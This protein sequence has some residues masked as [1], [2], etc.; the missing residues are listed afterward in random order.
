MMLKLVVEVCNWAPSPFA[1]YSDRSNGIGGSIRML[2]STN[3]HVNTYSRE[4]LTYVH[5]C[6]HKFTLMGWH[7]SCYAR[8]HFKKTHTK[9]Q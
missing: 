6:N 1:Y 7:D 5:N 9:N 8:V 2:T 4:L 3:V